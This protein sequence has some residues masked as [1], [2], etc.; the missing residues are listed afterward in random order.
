[1]RLQL[2]TAPPPLQPLVFSRGLLIDETMHFGL[3]QGSLVAAGTGVLPCA[4]K[5]SA[6]HLQVLDQIYKL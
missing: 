4:N 6:K 5:H 2:P 3:T 1:M